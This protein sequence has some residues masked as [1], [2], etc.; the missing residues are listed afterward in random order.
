MSKIREPRYRKIAFQIAEKIV[1]NEYRVGSKLHARSALS[2]TFG[3]SAETARKAINILSDLDIVKPI[4]GSGVEVLSR[5]KAKHFLNQA[6]E[7]TN[8]QTIHDQINDLIEN[9]RASLDNLSDSLAVLFD[10]TQRV[11]RHNPLTPYE[12]ILTNHSDQLGKSIGDLNIWQNTG[13]TIIALLHEEDLVVSPGPYAVIESGD[14]LYFV[15]NE[16]VFHAVQNF[17][18]HK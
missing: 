14:T 4:H 3:V 15:G 1:N 11:Q 12:L 8:I 16:T 13:A 18:N 9:Q 6:Q 7:T 10:Q 17:F 2:V 5:E